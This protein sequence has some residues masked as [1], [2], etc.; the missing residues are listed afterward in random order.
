MDFEFGRWV[1]VDAG[2][3]AVTVA[4]P[5]PI[6]H[7]HQRCHCSLAQPRLD[8]ETSSGFR[9][10]FQLREFPLFFTLIG[11]SLGLLAQL[12]RPAN[13]F[14]FH[15][16]RRVSPVLGCTA[17][18][19]SAEAFPSLCDAVGPIASR[20]RFLQCESIQDRHHTK[21]RSETDNKL[22]TQ[23]EFKFDSP[24]TS[25]SQWSIW[26]QYSKMLC[27]KPMPSFCVACCMLPDLIRPANYISRPINAKMD[28]I[29]PV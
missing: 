7:C 10:C 2:G 11:L 21:S 13:L 23:A 8:L 25:S 12:P 15:S 19:A 26:L 4:V 22:G 28:Q 17:F 20:Q 16:L 1:Y 24:L 14:E 6:P 27:S 29:H 5:P 3:V 18:L 9:A